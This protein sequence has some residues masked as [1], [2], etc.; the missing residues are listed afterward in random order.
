VSQALLVLLLQPQQQALLA[1][2]QQAVLRLLSCLA[3][4]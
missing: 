4:S 3:C 1:L 2:H